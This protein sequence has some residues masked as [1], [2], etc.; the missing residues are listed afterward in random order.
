MQPDTTPTG[1]FPH[2]ITSHLLPWNGLRSCGLRVWPGRRL[3]RSRAWNAAAQASWDLYRAAH[4]SRSAVVFI[5]E[6]L[7]VDTCTPRT[8]WSACGGYSVTR[9]GCSV[10]TV[11]RI[12]GWSP[13]AMNET[14]DAITIFVS[15]WR[16]R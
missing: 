10:T 5:L 12:Y 1:A 7:A 15:P 13:D 6:C 16:L 11:P 3:R 14:T 9:L 2:C 4:E 8:P